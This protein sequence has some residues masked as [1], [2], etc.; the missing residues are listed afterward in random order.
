[1]VLGLRSKS[2]RATS[3][4]VEYAVHLV[5]IKPWP[6]SPT[7]RTLRSVVLQWENGDRS[8]G[9]SSPV[10]P[11]LLDGRIA[12]NE[13]FKLRTSLKKAG[14]GGAFLK[15]VLDLNLYELRREK[16]ARGQHLGGAAVDL[17]EHG[18]IREP[19]SLCLPI[20]SRRSFR[21]AAQPF[22]FL[23]IQPFNRSDA[24]DEEEELAS[25]TD[26]EV[27]EEEEEEKPEIGPIEERLEKSSS[28]VLPLDRRV[29]KSVRSP[30]IAARSEDS[31]EEV[32]EIDV[33]ERV[34]GGSGKLRGRESSFSQR[35]RVFE[36]EARVGALETELREA[37]AVEIAAYSVVA[38]H[39]SS[40][41]KVHTP[42]RR[43]LR[44]YGGGG[45]ARSA[46]SGLVLAAKACGNDVPRLTFWL[47][48]AVA[49][50]A[51]VAEGVDPL[52]SKSNGKEPSPL[53]WESL[54]REEGESWEEPSSF[55]AVLEKIEAWIFS[56]V[57]E[58]L[59]WQTMTPRMHALE[60]GGVA[61]A[62]A[63]S[64]VRL[65]REAFKDACERLCPVRANGH[66][67][68]CLPTL[69]KLIMEQCV[70]RLDVAL[71][72]ALLREPGD[73]LPTDPISD[74]ITD[75]RVLPISASQFSFGAG[76]QLKN[77]IGNWSRGLSHWFGIDDN[78]T[79]GEEDGPPQEKKKLFRLLNALSDLLMLPKDMLLDQSIRRE[80]CPCFG[81][82]ILK[83]ILSRFEPD[84]FCPDSIPDNLLYSLDL[85]G[86]SSES[87][88]GEI[89]SF[90][91]AAD[92]V[93][94]SPP[95][96]AKVAIAIGGATIFRKSNTSDDE[97]DELVNANATF[98]LILPA[99]DRG[100]GSLRYQLLRQ[101][102]RSDE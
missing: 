15:N 65:W 20:S 7:L 32:K 11:S 25:F 58:S 78:F 67:C 51:A 80:V 39:G 63:R 76:A 8:S 73:D 13:T 16:S 41:V 97:L 60:R 44:L 93:V 28:D 95:A 57:V 40:A 84:E 43:L 36:L 91:C 5:E 86:E 79:D 1:M 2:R 26:D 49:L 21:N 96:A 9:S 37:A 31:A 24:G 53:R 89:E 77:T 48:N 18:V 66:E 100:E 35:L 50:R 72:N 70:A 94:Y 3:V 83:R 52:R 38:E 47:S 23:R 64:T 56:R 27:E 42:A 29:L 98:P 68:G 46:A 87:S 62:P 33:L 19:V 12:I 55:V 54:T 59:W 92:P 88:H 101:F 90:P 34:D 82:P 10:V 61:G 69:P 45:A 81:E 6:P 99:A 14:N 17:A 74:P 85:E 30:S 4:Q 75:P 22:L 71:F 102:W